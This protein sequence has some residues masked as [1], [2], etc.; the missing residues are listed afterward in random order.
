M[1]HD[2]KTAL[3]RKIIWNR[4]SI[5][6]VVGRSTPKKYYYLGAVCHLCVIHS[7]LIPSLVLLWVYYLLFHHPPFSLHWCS[8]NKNTW[9]IENYPRFSVKWQTRSSSEVCFTGTSKLRHGDKCHSILFPPYPP[10]YFDAIVASAQH[11]LFDGNVQ[12]APKRINDQ[13]SNF[14]MNPFILSLNIHSGSTK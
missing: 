9:I 14:K 11:A 10:C 13:Q 4:I 7:D 2:K 1:P 8:D 12:T 6:S 3:D 5:A